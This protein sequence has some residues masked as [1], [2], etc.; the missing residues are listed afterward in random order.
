MTFTSN[1]F[2][3]GTTTGNMSGM[4]IPGIQDHNIATSGYIF[5]MSAKFMW[6]YGGLLH[7]ERTIMIFC[8]TIETH[9]DLGI[10]Y[11]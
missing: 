2:H 9:G 11:F 6:T 10:P 4:V 7:W 8:L 5:I 1:Y 3:G